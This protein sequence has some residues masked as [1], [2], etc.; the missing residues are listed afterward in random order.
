MLKVFVLKFHTIA[1]I[2][3]PVISQ[4]WKSFVPEEGK[5]FTTV[6]IIPE[7][8]SKLT[9]IG[10]TPPLT[11]S[12]SEYRLL[13]KSLVGGVKQIIFG[14]N[15]I[16]SN[17]VQQQSQIIQLTTVEIQQFIDFFN[18]ALD[19]F[20]IY[21]INSPKQPQAVQREEKELLEL[22][23]GLFLNLSSQNFQVRV[24]FYIKN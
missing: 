12:V 19:A 4:K 20:Y 8:V 6:E 15:Y 21:R 7:T 1:K 14:I 18:W 10:F 3:I 24:Q 17:N 11:I 23:S 16:D 2:Q 9:S 22:F 13:V 5:E